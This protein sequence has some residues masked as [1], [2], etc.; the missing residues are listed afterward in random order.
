M[1][2]CNHN[3]ICY[4]NLELE[5]AAAN[6]HA[7]SD[8]DYTD[9]PPSPALPDTP[10]PR[11]RSM[12]CPGAPLRV[13]PGAT[14]AN[15]IVLDTPVEAKRIIIDLVSSDDEEPPRPV[16]VRDRAPIRALSVADARTLLGVLMQVPAEAPAP[17]PAPAPA[18]IRR[19]RRSERNRRRSVLGG[20]GGSRWNARRL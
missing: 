5:Y 18:A 19:R 9:Y 20:R 3:G 14:R 17:A 16:R 15:P 13:Q 2:T 7:S 12:V 10:P 1:S 11:L 6:D 8:S 4:C